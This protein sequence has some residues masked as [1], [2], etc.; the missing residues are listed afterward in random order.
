METDREFLGWQLRQHSLAVVL[1]DGMSCVQE[2]QAAGVVRSWD[3]DRISHA[4]RSGVSE[5]RVFQAEELGV[6]FLGWN[7][8]V[9][10]SIVYRLPR[11]ASELAASHGQRIARYPLRCRAVM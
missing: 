8:P 5:L 4:T 11:E 2:L 6:R 3:A 1:V 9:C 10:R 7:R